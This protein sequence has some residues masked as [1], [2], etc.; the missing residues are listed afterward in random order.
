MQMADS[1]HQARRPVMEVFPKVHRVTLGGGEDGGPPST[2]AYLV[3]GPERCVFIDAGFPEEDRTR[4]LLDYWRG[5]LGSPRVGWVLIS[6][7]HHEH[8]GGAR[9]LKDATRARVA[10][11]RGDAHA[12]EEEF[13]GGAPLV[14]DLLEG[15]ETF[16]LGG[17]RRI[18]AVATPGHTAGTVC[19]FSEPDRLLFTGDHVMGQGTVVIRTDQGGS[20]AQHI[21]SLRALMDLDAKAILSGHGEPITDVKPKLEELIRHRLEREAQVLDLLRQ[22]MGD[23][24]AFL[25]RLYAQ[26]PPRLLGLARHQVIA[27]LEKLVEDGHAAVIERGTVYRAV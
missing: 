18:R 8:A 23:V 26:T 7:L 16:D 13:G 20:M 22:G 3:Q 4:P 12:I 6:H 9:L 11:G 19:F 15:G 25:S 10:A 21:Q 5:A 14:D 27:H 2:H 24:D 17:G 1:F